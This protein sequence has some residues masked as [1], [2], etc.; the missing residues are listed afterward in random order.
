MKH[1]LGVMDLMTSAEVR[2]NGEKRLSQEKRGR[3]VII[4]Y[5]CKTF[6]VKRGKITQFS[7]AEWYTSTVQVELEIAQIRE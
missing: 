4:L 1:E 6:A 5:M 3:D 7:V 2:R